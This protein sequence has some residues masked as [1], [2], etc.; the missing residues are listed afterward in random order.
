MAQIAATWNE[1]DASHDGV[2]SRVELQNFMERAN[3][4]MARDTRKARTIGGLGFGLI[5]MAGAIVLNG[6]GR[7]GNHT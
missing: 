1:L 4:D 6:V 7:P 3:Q 2:V 5:G